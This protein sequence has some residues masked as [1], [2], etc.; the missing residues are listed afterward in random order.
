MGGCREA[1]Q[2][3]ENPARFIFRPSF[4]GGDHVVEQSVTKS[5]R[6]YL[7]KLRQAGLEPRFGVLFGSNVTGN[8]DEWSDIDLVVVSPRFDSMTSQKLVNTLWHIA[9]RTDARIE[10][11]PC[12]EKQ[13]EEDDGTPILE[14]A[15]REGIKIEEPCPPTTS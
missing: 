2:R 14:V 5:V 10:P 4:K 9:A 1:R 13:W 11:I 3:R 15:R 6:G 12:G 7:E 8:A